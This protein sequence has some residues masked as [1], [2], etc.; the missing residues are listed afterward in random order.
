MAAEISTDLEVFVTQEI[1]SG[2]FS[3]RGSVIEYALRL[4]QR[5]REEAIHG[6]KL[7][8]DDVTAGRTQ[9]LGQAFSDLRRELDV[10]ED[11]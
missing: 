5:D 7:G 1:A 9:P 8:L 10:P 3:D 4:M 6:I 2:R 11:A